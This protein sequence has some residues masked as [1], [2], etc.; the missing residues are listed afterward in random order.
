M[1]GWKVPTAK[2]LFAI[3]PVAV[4]DKLIAEL[5]VLCSSIWPV[6]SAG[7]ALVWAFKPVSD[8]DRPFKVTL[9]FRPSLATN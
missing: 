7:V 6:K 9:M 3:L 4:V 5:V 2:P 8:A 1:L